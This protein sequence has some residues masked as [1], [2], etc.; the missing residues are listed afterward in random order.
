MRTWNLTRN[1]I[2]AAV[3]L[4]VGIA[5]VFASYVALNQAPP[6]SR[7]PGF[8]AWDPATSALAQ[9]LKGAGAYQ[10]FILESWADK[11]IP[12]V[13]ALAVPYLSFLLLIPIVIPLL[14][15]RVSFK[16]FLTVSIALIV[17]QLVL[18]LS[19]LLFQSEV[20][21]NVEA[22]DGLGG[23]LVN[24]VWGND[25]PFN[26]FPS[27]HCTWTMIGICALMRLR[28]VMPRTAWTMSAWLSLVFPATVMLRQH[29]LIDVFAGVFVGF[30]IY[31]AVMF[32]VE[33]PVLVAA[34]GDDLVLA[35]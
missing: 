1:Q 23:S 27:G 17:S 25:Q 30:A 32:I 9:P 2:I 31:W 15:L 11:H 20:I 28:K 35:P 19:Y 5:L 7:W 22:G 10:S 33:R 34:A 16:R 29:Y 12:F 26:C 6:P 3:G 8:F 18:D 4:M 24:L 14:S 21:R 13:P